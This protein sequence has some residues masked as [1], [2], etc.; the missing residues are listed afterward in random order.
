M[1]AS[2]DGCKYRTVQGYQMNDVAVRPSSGT[3]FCLEWRRV[4]DGVIIGITK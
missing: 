2:L 4:K 3:L 1:A